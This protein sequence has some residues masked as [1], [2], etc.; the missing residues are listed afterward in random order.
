MLSSTNISPLPQ[1]QVLYKISTRLHVQRLRLTV[2]TG[3]DNLLQLCEQSRCDF[4]TKCKSQFLVN[5]YL[6]HLDKPLIKRS[7][8]ESASCGMKD[9]RFTGPQ[10]SL[11][12]A[13]FGHLL[14]GNIIILRIFRSIHVLCVDSGDQLVQ[15]FR[16]Y[17]CLKEVFMYLMQNVVI[18]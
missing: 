17:Q 7:L 14:K 4:G 6:F 13:S 11:F 16:F 18:N 2:R 8:I 1:D 5:S 9:C 10:T 3:N 15:N 12:D